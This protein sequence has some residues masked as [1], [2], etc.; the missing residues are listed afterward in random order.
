MEQ[1]CGYCQTVVANETELKIH[2]DNWESDGTGGY[3]PKDNPCGKKRAKQVDKNLKN[4]LIKLKEQ[5]RM[6][7]ESKTLK[8]AADALKK[9]PNVFFTPDS[10]EEVTD[11]DVVEKATLDKIQRNLGLIRFM[12][13]EIDEF[14]QRIATKRIY[15]KSLKQENKNLQY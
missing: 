13:E 12:Q 6:D 7:L 5:E 14:E 8:E 11:H 3:Y 1:M 10:G 15:I 2:W 9:N 4:W